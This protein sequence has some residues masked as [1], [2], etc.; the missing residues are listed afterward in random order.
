MQPEITL[1][2]YAGA[3]GGVAT[4]S[5]Q[6][7]T[8]LSRLVRVRHLFMFTV[9]SITLNQPTGI[10]TPRIHKSA[11]CLLPHT[12]KLLTVPLNFLRE[13]F[14]VLR[15]PHVFWRKDV[16]LASHN[17][18]A[19]WAFVLCSRRAHYFSFVLPYHAGNPLKH[20]LFTPWRLFLRRL[21][22]QRLATHR[23]NLI[24]P[25]L[26]AA[27][28]W[29]EYLRINIAAIHIIPSPPFLAH[30]CQGIIAETQAGSATLQVMLTKMAG[31]RMVLSV[32][33]ME[34]YKN[35]DA[36]LAIAKHVHAQ[37]ENIAFV[38]AGEG[39]LFEKIKSAAVGFDRIVFT[40]RLN[41]D[42]IRTLTQSSWIFF[43]PAVLESQGIVV[44]DALTFGK[45][46][47][48]SNS[49]ALP[50]LIAGSDA[51]YVMECNAPDAPAQFFALLQ[52]LQDEK[53]YQ[54]MSE[55]ALKLAKERYAYDNWYNAIAKLVGSA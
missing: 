7:C 22:A 45:P 20:L 26:R 1:V 25:T 24:A 17:P 29:A 33:H 10:P 40:G 51:G 44:M 27:E 36:W 14:L 54:H 4:H 38:W 52:Q 23:F 30:P 13:W 47:I 31:K 28:V 32:G 53:L 12:L 21:V 18:K 9:N 8:A 16:V 19:F 42:D 55:A 49:D 5:N 39:P 43:H 41:Q 46:V 50:G 48:V 15:Y 2:V 11:E 35:P 3:Y 34:D 37:D 6:F